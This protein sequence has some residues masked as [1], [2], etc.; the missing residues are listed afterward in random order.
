MI[1]LLAI[2]IC[3]SNIPFFKTWMWMKLHVD[4]LINN[5]VQD[6]VNFAGLKL[7]ISKACSP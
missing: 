7:A 1:V 5:A 4:V 3:S 2:G 6:H